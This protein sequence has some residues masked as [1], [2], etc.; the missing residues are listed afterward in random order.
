MS[1]K[2]KKEKKKKKKKKERKKEKE[3]RP[4]YI[5]IIIRTYRLITKEKKQLFQGRGIVPDN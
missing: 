5:H 3:K 4:T 2:K 1:K